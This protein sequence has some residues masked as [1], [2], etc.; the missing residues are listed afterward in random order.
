MHYRLK[1]TLKKTVFEFEKWLLLLILPCVYI[2]SIFGQSSE[3]Q[4]KTSL[5]LDSMKLGDA[6]DTI[7]AHT[8]YYFTYNSNLIDEDKI[9]YG[10]YNEQPLSVV[11]QH[12]LN[13]STLYFHI[14]KK[15]IIISAFP[16]RQDKNQV[17]PNVSN[18]YHLNGKVVDARTNKPLPYVNI[19][20]L[21]KVMG[22]TT[23]NDGTFH[24]NYSR[25]NLT[26]TVK[27]SFIGYKNELL[28]LHD[29]VLRYHEIKLEQNYISL[30][31]VII[32]S[33][34]PKVL[35]VSAIQNFQENY[36]QQAANFTSFYRESVK[37]NHN[38]MI[39]LESILQVY[40]SPYKDNAFQ[41]DA[42]RILRG[43]KIYDADNLDTVSFRLQGGVEGCLM[44]D[45]VQ[46]KP[47]FLLEELFPLYD[48]KLQDISTFNNQPVYVIDCILKE[49]I[50][51]PLTEGR[52]YLKVQDLAIIRA[53]FH[54]PGR[55]V[56]KLTSRFVKHKSAK[57]KATPTRLSY[58]VNYQNLNGKYYLSHSKG[59][60]KFRVKNKKKLFSS[61]FDIN[62]EMV[63]TQV[64]TLEVKKIKRI[65]R[66]KPDVILS[67]E[68]QG[69]D[70][71]FW[72][73]ATFIEPEED[74]QKALMRIPLVPLD[75]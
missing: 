55:I 62:F 15:Q 75:K 25:Q 33:S 45:V 64:D 40:K 43:R 7:S 37:K 13:D 70:A 56:K 52:L 21:G 19:G 32:R 50:M 60:L 6:L 41:I 44:M 69:Y 31:E 73:N 1:S 51:E 49:G 72:G 18:A 27:I 23:N 47:D 14:L 39:Y 30:Q 16:Y 11:L 26:D 12:V 34:D 4:Q 65:D 5:R 58:A 3:L 35:I 48:Y 74:I 29:S 68:M 46:N 61:T 22:T 59:D 71:S 2:S 67:K 28:I 54:Y 8:N 38:H 9:V 66:L 63:T 36:M 53:E 10:N 20:I 17:E 57:T 24:L 42:A